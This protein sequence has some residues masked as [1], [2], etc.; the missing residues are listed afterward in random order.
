[1][2]EISSNI[3]HN[4]VTCQFRTWVGHLYL[5]LSQ[6]TTN[7]NFPAGDAMR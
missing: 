4:Y 6:C 3:Q 5:Q 2:L 1:M 7:K